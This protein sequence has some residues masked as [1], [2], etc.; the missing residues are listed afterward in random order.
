MGEHEG[1]MENRKEIIYTYIWDIVG[2]PATPISKHAG[3]K[4]SACLKIGRASQKVLT[5]MPRMQSPCPH[6]GPFSYKNSLNSSIVRMGRWKKT[7]FTHKYKT[8]LKFINVSHPDHKP[9]SNRSHINS[10]KCLFTVWRARKSVRRQCQIDRL[11]HNRKSLK[12][13]WCGCLNS[14]RWVSNDKCNQRWLASS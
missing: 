7:F 1:C 3:T 13:R 11:S 9:L 5:S 2:L 4:M 14:R 10:K 8:S 12:H 6:R